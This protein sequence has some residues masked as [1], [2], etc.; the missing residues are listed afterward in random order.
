[1]LDIHLTQFLASANLTTLPRKPYYNSCKNYSFPN[2]S[3]ALVIKVCCSEKVK[4]LL[5]HEHQHF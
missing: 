4:W 3:A 2:S 1:M 5:A